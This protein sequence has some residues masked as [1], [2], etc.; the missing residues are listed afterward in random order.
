MMPSS[1]DRVTL[2]GLRCRG[3][4]SSAIVLL[5]CLAASGRAQGVGVASPAVASVASGTPTTTSSTPPLAPIPPRPMPPAGGFQVQIDW[6]V[7]VTYSDGYST[8]GSL[9]RPMEQ[10]PENGWPVVVCVHPFGG[11]RGSDL[12][13]QLLIA[14]QGYAV[15]SY[16]VRAQGQ[17][18]VSNPGHHQGGSTLWGPVERLDLAEQMQFVGQHVPYKGIVNASRLAVIGRSQGAAHAWLAAA[19]SGS[20]VAAPGRPSMVFPP[21]RCVA[22]FDLV[23]DS[24]EDWTRGGRLFSSWLIDAINPNFQAVAMDAAF[25]QR[26]RHAFLQQ[27]PGALRAQLLSDGRDVLPRIQQ[28]N[29]PVLFAYAYRDNVGSPLIGLQALESR[30]GL[31]RTML[32]NVGHGVVINEVEQ[33][34]RS[35]STLRWLHRYLW[36]EGNEIDLEQ[37]HVLAE[38]PSDAS[39]LNNTQYP[40]GRAQVADL[41][42]SSTADK[43]FLSRARVLSVAPAK[44]AKVSVR[45]EIQPWATNFTPADYLDDAS[46]RALS[47]VLAACPLSQI[48]YS[49]DTAYEQQFEGSAKLHLTMI[50]RQPV[51]QLSIALTMQS[52]A[53]AP[54]VA[55]ASYVLASRSSV[56]GVREVHDVRLPPIAA[57]LPAG[58]IVT[59]LLRNLAL[60]DA[61]MVPGLDVAPIFQDFQVDVLEG[62]TSDRGSWLELPIDQVAPRLVADQTGLQLAQ[63][64]PIQLTLRGGIHRANSA[65]FGLV[66]LSGQAPGTPFMN[67]LLPVEFDWLVAASAGGTGALFSGALGVLDG[68]GNAGMTHDLSSLPSLPQFLNGSQLTFAA[69]VWDPT[70]AS[71]AA[72]NAWDV[73]ML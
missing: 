22:A 47:N 41:R 33:G 5:L 9:L 20:S 14:S 10:A 58:A 13:L 29:V 44:H 73:M 35:I 32:G 50:P 53:H 45:Q 49:F 57:R 51:W 15:W 69:F 72:S 4:L 2:H 16:D 8:W 37:P 70:G 59:L 68:Q 62:P 60:R 55:L 28:S 26:C 17:A 21:V 6:F 54:R 36:N 71:G 42:P 19:W 23:A 30:V 43:L 12:H 39:L 11:T 66:G 64:G 56:A 52:H 1:I 67:A 7:P 3:P 65:Y 34:F 24:V 31:Q 25:V 48:G 40:W 63:P 27:D 38:L 18:V 61:P 46:V